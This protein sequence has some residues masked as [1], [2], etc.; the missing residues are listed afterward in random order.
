MNEELDRTW[1]LHYAH[2]CRLY[3]IRPL[4]GTHHYI[5]GLKYMNQRLV[6]KFNSEL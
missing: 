5:E 2:N 6:K 4:K 1:K 3:A